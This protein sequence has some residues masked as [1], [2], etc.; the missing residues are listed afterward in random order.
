MINVLVSGNVGVYLGMEVT[1]YSLMKHNRNVNLYVL[2]SSFEQIPQ[3][4]DNAVKLYEGLDEDQKKKI[5]NIVR[6]FDP[7]N[8]SVTFIDPIELYRTHLE[9]GANEFSC[10][11]PYA[12]FRLLADLILTDLDDVLYL[13]C[14]TVI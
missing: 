5:T 2:T 6:Y 11:T 3:P 10:F 12:A 1:I 9:G 13:D 8:S 14:D 4:W 7:D